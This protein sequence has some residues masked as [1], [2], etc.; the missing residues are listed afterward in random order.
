MPYA[1]IATLPFLL[2]LTGQPYNILV[3]EGILSSPLP[4]SLTL[5]MT[6]IC[7]FLYL[8]YDLIKKFDTLLMAVAAGTVAL[9]IIY[10]GLFLIALMTY[11]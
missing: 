1:T 4:K 11:F 5:F 2:S 6:K 10:E 7:N 8:T 9:N 3:T